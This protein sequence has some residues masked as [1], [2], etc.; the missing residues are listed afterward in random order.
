M[1]KI[2]KR[3]ILCL[4]LALFHFQSIA[5]I[6]CVSATGDDQ[7]GDGS[8][9]HPWKT[10]KYAVTKVSANLGHTIRIGAGTF[11]ENGLVEV[12]LGVSIEGAGINAT[13]FKAA[14][15]FYYHP[16]ADPGY[17]PDKFLISLSE[18]NPRDGNQ[19]LRNFSIN[20]NSKQLH[21]GIF[22]RNRIK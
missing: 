20:G 5:D 9:G 17:S 6:Y 13:V 16:S 18:F 15:S 19:T 12:P 14:S 8:S 4:V 3:I 2:L 22:V 21:G 1:S 7:F 11:I 10:L